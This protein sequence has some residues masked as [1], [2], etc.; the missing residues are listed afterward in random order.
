MCTSFPSVRDVADSENANLDAREVEV[1]TKTFNQIKR[2]DLSGN[3]L[4]KEAVL[5]IIDN[6]HHLEELSLR[7]CHLDDKEIEL[8]AGKYSKLHTLY[9][10]K[11]IVNADDNKITATGVVEIAKHM[12]NLKKFY[13]SNGLVI[14]AKIIS[15]M[16]ALSS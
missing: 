4:Y 8:L 10:S 14:Q 2:L 3:K 7:Q 15:E 11:P 16:M 1:L 6:C 13:I 12:V 9:L 5:S